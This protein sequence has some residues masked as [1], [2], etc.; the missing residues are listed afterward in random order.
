MAEFNPD[1][2]LQQ[3]KAK[4]FNPDTYLQQVKATKQAQSPQQIPDAADKAAQN[5]SP[6]AQPTYGAGNVY[7]AYK[8][9]GLSGAFQTLSANSDKMASGPQ[10]PMEGLIKSGVSPAGGLSLLNQSGALASG[11]RIA[12]NTGLGYIQGGA[13]GA[14]VGAAGA[15]LGEAAQVLNKGGS[16][17]MKGL[18]RFTGPQA[19]AYLDNPQETTQIAQTLKDPSK[20]PDLQN[21]AVQAINQSRTALKSQGLENASVLKQY[22]SGKQVE[23]NPTDYMGLDPRVDE[24][25]SSSL[26]KPTDAM[27]AFKQL[28]QGTPNSA[29]IDANDANQIKRFLQEGAEFGQGTHT[30]PIQAAKAGNL[31]S[32]SAQM[33][34][35][36]ESA[37]PEAS[38]LNKQMQESLLLQKALGAAKNSPIAFVSSESPDRL[39]TLAKTEKY[40]QGGLLDF[41][42]RLGA[43]KEIA[44]PDTGSGI[45]SYI[46]RLVGRGGLRALN[47]LPDATDVAPAANSALLQGLFGQSSSTPKQ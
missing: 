28:V 29:S 18:S 21:Q 4:Q 40:G 25:L 7:S 27:G 19:Q 45:P 11:A 41:G 30:D 20:Y 39:A 5:N 16:W 36:I 33:R 43:A 22:L 12:A 8:S 31:A 9:G 1:E 32:K 3:V 26:N 6:N 35:V 47:A 2:Y 13:Q 15:G 34:G 10:G 46:S 44:A 37:A 23:I 17:F 38:D 24:L 42:Q 14:A